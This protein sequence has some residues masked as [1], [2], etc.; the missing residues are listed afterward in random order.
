MTFELKID[1]RAQ[2]D[3]FAV[4]WYQEVSGNKFL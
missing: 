3:V 2:S 1:K 4:F